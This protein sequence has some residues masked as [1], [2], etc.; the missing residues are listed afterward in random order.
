MNDARNEHQVVTTSRGAS[1]F[2]AIII[3][4]LSEVVV[5]KS[6]RSNLSLGTKRLP[7]PPYLQKV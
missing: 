6:A 1:F 4:T 2:V 7:E 3:I 5:K